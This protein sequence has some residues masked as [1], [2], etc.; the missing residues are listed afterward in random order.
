MAG[1][2]S[3][4]CDRESLT[5]LLRRWS[6]GDENVADEVMPYVYEELRR[7]AARFFQRER[8]DHTLQPTAVVNEI[9]VRLHEETGVRFK[10]RAH[11]IGHTAQMMRRLLVDHA[12]KRNAGRRGGGWQRVS[13]TDVDLSEKPRDVVALDDALR[14]LA[15]K[16]PSMVRLVELR[17]FGGLTLEETAEVLGI[18]RASVVLA[19]RRT[20]VWLHRELKPN[21]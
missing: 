20:K 6:E 7:I 19:W 2:P 10:N 18:S 9:Y 12:R 21:V 16:D 4:R 13:L 11:F 3:E 14:R 8:S 17:F 5:L 15:A 1:E